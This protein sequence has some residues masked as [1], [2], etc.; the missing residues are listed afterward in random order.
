MGKY[1]YIDAI[2]FYLFSKNPEELLPQFQQ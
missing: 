2:K 1:I